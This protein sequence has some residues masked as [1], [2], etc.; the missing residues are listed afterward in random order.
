MMMDSVFEQQNLWLSFVN[1]VDVL[2][3]NQQRLLPEVRAQLPS[4]RHHLAV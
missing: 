2:Q 3:L 1:A 4:T